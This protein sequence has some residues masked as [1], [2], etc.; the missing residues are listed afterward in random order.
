M[1]IF[2]LAHDPADAAQALGD[3]HVVKMTLETAQL[4]STSHQVKRVNPYVYRATHHNHPC[5]KWVQECR[6]NYAW[7]YD[8]FQELC[9]EFSFRRGK[10]HAASRML[11]TFHT[12]PEYMIGL[13][14]R[15][16][17]TPVA[18]CMPD[19]YRNACPIQA[20]RMYY[21]SKYKAGIVKYNW[22][23]PEPEW[24]QTAVDY[25]SNPTPI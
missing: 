3:K 22:G 11:P 16:H 15:E 20:Y 1:N 13:R 19:I 10:E 12:V 14:G 4:L 25:I 17:M 5:T 7:T 18:Q 2:Y 9:K 6:A 23:R 8:L 21:A 24:L